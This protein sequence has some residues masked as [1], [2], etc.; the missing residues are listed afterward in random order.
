[1]KNPIAEFWD[2]QPKA[3]DNSPTGAIKRLREFLG[4]IE[5]RFEIDE[6]FVDLEILAEAIEPR[7]CNAPRCGACY[8]L[9]G[10]KTAADDFRKYPTL[11]R[12]AA[13]LSEIARVTR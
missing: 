11:G 3:F 10:L 6:A 12:Q 1:M 4:A 9:A 7:K 2:A 8:P 5:Y 13:L